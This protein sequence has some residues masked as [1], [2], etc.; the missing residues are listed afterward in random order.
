MTTWNPRTKSA[1]AIALAITLT[2]PIAVSGSQQ[3]DEFFDRSFD[4]GWVG[5]IKVGNERVL[6]QLNLNLG[7]S[8]CCNHGVGFVVLQDNLGG[9]PSGVDVL[10]ADFTTVSEKR[11]QFRVDDNAP[12]GRRRGTTTFKLNAKSGKL[13][14]KASGE[15]KGS[16][17][18]VPM[19]ADLPLQ[20]LWAGSVK[21]GGKT[22]FLL[23]QLTDNADGTVGGYAVVDGETGDV[24]ATADRLGGRRAGV[25][26]T[27]K[28][29]SGDLGIDLSL[30]K[31]NKQLG[32][33][34][35]D[36]SKSAKAK[37]KPAGSKGKPMKVTAVQRTALRDVSV[38]QANTVTVRGKNFVAGVNVHVDNEEFL[39]YSVEFKSAKLLE[40]VITPGASVADG[41]SAAVLVIN[42]DGQTGEHA[43][44][45]TAISDDGGG[46]DGVS[47]AAEIQPIFDLTCALAGCHSTGSASGGLVLAAG[48]AFDNLVG[49][50]SSQQPAVSH[51]ASGDPD[52]S[53]LVRKIEGAA[54]ISGG[55][56]PLN[57]TPLTA[58]QIAS[59]RTWIAEGAQNN[60]RP[61]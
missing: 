1:A 59:I 41:T 51:V 46:E 24:V 20:K 36:D 57:R 31:G 9:A 38:G 29:D 37:F 13:K 18:L 47:F 10:E 11:I 56:M 50:P 60:R 53:Y 48:S 21:L 40:V 44:A 12:L 4:G 42:A 33:K 16:A 3:N 52:N 23:L 17:E 27:I 32:G 2:L 5:S 6:L 26:G 61:Q 55:R 8:D 19:S 45:L 14:G 28:L 34:I 49:V 25:S 35:T 15:I 39:V 7:A 22:V 58:A 30:Q 43:N 54:G